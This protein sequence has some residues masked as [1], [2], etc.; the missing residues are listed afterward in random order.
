MFNRVQLI[1][2]TTTLSASAITAVATPA[3]AD[4]AV[5][6]PELRQ[7]RSVPGD[8]VP[9]RPLPDDEAAQRAVKSPEPV[10]WPVAARAEVDLSAVDGQRGLAASGDSPVRVARVDAPALAQRSA[11]PGGRVAVETFD[12]SA[13][14]KAGLDGVLVRVADRD[15]GKL[16]VRLDYSGFAG[17][18]G[19]DYGSRLRFEMLPECALSTPDKEEC[20]VGTPLRTDNNTGERALTAEV[21]MPAAHARSAGVL[22]AATA[23]TSGSG[24]DYGATPLAPSG[25]WNAGGS[26]GDFSYSYPFKLPAVPG[27]P[28]PSIALGYSSGSVDGRTSATNN[29][30]S[31]VGDGWELSGGGYIERRYKGCAEDL[32]G[33]Q[34]QTKTGDLCWATDNATL[35]LGGVSSELVWNGTEGLWHPKNDDGSRIQKLTGA[36]NGDNDGEHWKVTATD[37]TQYFLGLNRLPGWVAGK[38]ETN[39]A[40]TTPVFGNNDG[41]PCKAGA[42]ADSW[43]QQVWRWNVDLMIDPRGNATTYYY[44]T[45]VNHY[46]RNNTVSATTPYVRAGLVRRIEYGL[47]S[48]ALFA[49]PPARVWFDT[50]E[51]CL[52]G[53]S[54]TCAPEQLNSST[55]GSWPDV[56]AD[57]LCAAGAPC[58]DHAPAFFSRKRL[59]KVLTQIRRDDVTGDAQFKDVESWALRHEF[60]ATG[61]GL[62]P[63]LWLAGIK[64]TGHVGGTASTPEMTFGGTAMPNRVDS[65]EGLAPITRYRITGI[66]NETGGYTAI[67][68][69]GPD[70]RRA[71]RMPASPEYNTLRCYPTRWSPPNYPEPIVDWFHKYVVTQVIEDD[72]TGGSA[73]LR[74]S[75]EYLG[76][77]AWHYDENDFGTAEQRTWSSWRGYGV[78]RT[79]AGEPTGVQSITE[80][81]YLRGMDGDTLPGGTKR[82]VHVADADGGSIEDHERLQGFVREARQY[83]G[84]KIVSATVNDPWLHGP[85][86]TNGDDRAFLLKTGVVRGRTLL[87]DNTWR[88]T[89]VST[90]FNRQGLTEQV[91]DAGDTA[92]IGDEKCTRTTYA[93]NEGAWLLNAASRVRTIAVACSAGDGA[94]TD[95]VTDV[96]S[97]FD[98]QAHGAAPTRGEVTTAERWNGTG[99]QVV[100]KTKY[101]D[102]G[103]PVEAYD[104]AN[105]KSTTA[106]APAAD[107][108]ARTVTTTNPL[109]HTSTNTFEP[110][111]GAPVKE[112]GPNN[113]AVNL[114]YDPLGRLS[115][116]WL[117]GRGTDKTPNTEYTYDY[118]TDAPT[119][120]TTKSLLENQ[121]YSTSY[122]L[123]DGLL[124]ERQT[125]VPAIAGGRVLTDT[126]YDGRG[127]AWKTNAAYYNEDAP[128]PALHGVLDNAVPNQ[129]VTQFDQLGRATAVIYRKLDV[130]QWR[131]TNA[132]EGDRTHTTPPAG[133]TAFTVIK[134]AQGNVVERRQYHG[135]T[136]S[137]DFDATTYAY[138][139]KGQLDTVTDAAGNQWRYEYDLLG[140]KAKDHDPDRGTTTYAYNDLDQV[141]STTDAR[142]KTVATVYDVLGRKISQHDGSTTG[143]KL[144]EWTYD[145][146]KKGLLTESIR[147]LNGKAYSRKVGFYDALNRPTSN[148]TTIPTGEGGLTGT[149]TFRTG[150]TPV[151]GLVSM[152]TMP[153]AGGLDGEAILTNYNEFDMPVKTYGHQTYAKEHLYSKYGE[154]LRLTLGD[155]TNS[156]WVTNNYQE[157]TRRLEQTII[158]RN[159][160]TGFRL[161]DRTYSYDPSG[162][163]KRIADQPTGGPQDVQCFD[164]DHLRRM[165]RAYTSASGDCTVQPS[166]TNLGGTAPYWY[167]YTFDKTG[168]R[169]SEVKH[170]AQG[171]TTRTSTYPAAGTARPH[172]VLSV[173]QAGP[174]GTS[175]D[176]FTYDE[177][178]NTK[179]RKVGGSTQTLEWDVEG[180]LT[181]AIEADGKTS[182]Y[183]Y[184]ASG[185][186]FMKKEPGRTTLYLPGTELVLDTGNNTVKGKRY[187]SHAGSTV[188]VRTAG[189]G[190]DFLLA[191]HQGTASLSVGGGN[192]AVTRRYTD[193]FGNSRGTVP[194]TWPDD[195]GFVGGTQDRTGLVHLGA[196]QYD[197]ATG[198]FLS[199]DPI[200]DTTDPQ[201]INGYSYANNSPVSDSDP[202]G[203][204]NCGP[205]GVLCGYDPRMFDQG[206]GSK[207]AKDAARQQ[208]S[209]EKAVYTAINRYYDSVK[210]NRAA[211]DRAAAAKHGMSDEEY[212][213][214]KAVASSNKSW[215]DVVAE[216]AGDIVL[217]LIGYNDVR[218][219]FTKGDL[220]A[221]AGL[222]PW[223]KFLK[224]IKSAARV[225]SAI[226][227]AN[228]WTD[229]VRD[230]RSR[231]RKVEETAEQMRRAEPGSACKINSFV[232]GTQVL[233]ADGSSKPIEQIKIGDR[234]LAWDQ[235][236]G[237][238]AA[239]PVTATILGDGLKH[240]VELTIDTRDGA[241]TVT[242]TGNHPFW[243]PDAEK[244]VL[245]AEL[246]AGDRLLTHSG[247]VAAVAAT[248]HWFQPQQ[249]N[250]LT[251]DENHTY[252]VIAGGTPILVHNDDGSS[253]IGANGTQITSSTVWQRGALRIDVEN[254]SPGGRPGQMH[255]QVQ[256]NG[257]KSSD[258]PKYQY[259]FEARQ[260]DGLPKSLQKELAKTDFER[261]VT[262]GLGFLGEPC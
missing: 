182:E 248:S 71:D 193:P 183:V 104:A 192:L 77:P 49:A 48:N 5:R 101:D 19:A 125:Q 247:D 69:S 122:K 11:T 257:V 38:P 205:D 219:C 152:T 97:S 207:A 3:V 87:A 142:G 184:D 25:S 199:V 226:A 107:F 225:I 7:E 28:L 90:T 213:E 158:D 156:A 20:R 75:Y 148:I 138:T 252:Y 118:R 208:W 42:F 95:V 91:D 65:L 173:D 145:T 136:T 68:Y 212:R 13:A 100:A 210:R 88:R 73:L 119:V 53:G 135:A 111:F 227:S 18:F 146:L 6:L 214:T 185:A 83:Q 177:V 224:V 249:V 29:Q 143:T 197:P 126:W 123:Y 228:R 239:K 237:E 81:L 221:C 86:A 133:N 231:I 40:W 175:R 51:R 131:T 220:W 198:R 144:A 128:A 37:G 54:I 60:P 223:G 176:E 67:G 47:R 14:E 206:D 72:R 179:A 155:G 246:K 170:T 187:Y 56:P 16:S 134:D 253:M 108:P 55:A 233:M 61:D 39:S 244:W 181:K 62:S 202:G 59:V 116:V 84:G 92:V 137:G 235:R 200:M 70:C 186:R 129:T 9:V 160:T 171:D 189:A 209:R 159:T 8:P 259:N 215:W 243:S 120:V 36:A 96:R 168:N 236:T 151:T 109:N 103:R 57:A 188:A 139:R 44:D 117:L 26:S 12:R 15:G 64:H 241:R 169:V 74:T 32:G 256:V 149:Y 50:A 1:A 232:Q 80:T 254:P 115:K 258:A 35:V 222:I 30:A 63:S 85:T 261:G 230:A 23:G 180:R 255:L 167:D 113:E 211:T 141:V 234:V 190:L 217:D 102:Y 132:Y 24:G 154:T 110:A 242:A 164:Y 162:N 21:E 238:T 45:E 240:L 204:R 166:T 22:L 195:K 27:G 262:K 93:R 114:A 52:P 153:A 157:G 99:W 218:D 216:Q 43:C 82:D 196:R 174:S 161:A 147:Y 79:L 34:G 46:G 76:D 194:G 94:A 250:N 191:D 229:K 10:R 105:N 33:N 78:V 98:N 66:S 260:F 41:E 127:A 165:N 178:G 121:T 163:I 124:R 251:V 150:Y 4:I 58:D 172:S 245:T 130:E 106:Y 17:A 2:L 112:V 201:Q 31:V 89:Q 203:L 140:R